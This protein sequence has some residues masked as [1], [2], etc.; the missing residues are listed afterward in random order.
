VCIGDHPAYLIDKVTT[1]AREMDG[2]EIAGGLLGE[3][4]PMAK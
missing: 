4:V 1:C 2:L 3:P